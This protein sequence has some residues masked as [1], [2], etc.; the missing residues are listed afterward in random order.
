MRNRMIMD[1]YIWMGLK[2]MHVVLSKI[3]FRD[4]SLFYYMAHRIEEAFVSSDIL[5][6]PSARIRAAYIPNTR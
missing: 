4:L 6:F 3:L 1:S 2:A 5:N